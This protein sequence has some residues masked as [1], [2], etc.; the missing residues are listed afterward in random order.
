MAGRGQLE[1]PVLPVLAAVREAMGEEPMVTGKQVRLLRRKQME[2]KSQEAA[3]AAAGMSVRTA[4]RWAS[5]SLPSATK[6]T[7]HW[8]T[9]KDPFVGV[10]EEELVPLL[11]RDEKGILEAK[12]LFVVLEERHPGRFDPGQLRTLQRRLRDWRALRGPAKE[13]FFEQ[14]HPPGREGQF[15][16]T[17]ANGLEVT[18]SGGQLDH[19]L[20]EFILSRSGW[21]WFDIAYGETFEAMLLGLQG[22]LWELDGAPAVVRHDNLSAATHELRRTGGRTLTTRFKDF[23]DHYGL[24]STRIVPGEAHQNGVVEQGHDTTKSAIAQAL[25]LRGSRDFATVAEYRTF[26][27]AVRARLNARIAS[28]L[29]EERPHLR[30]LPPTA[31]PA[32]TTSHP[33]VRRWSTIRVGDRAYSVPSRLIGHQVEARQHADVVEVLY[34]GRVVETMARLRG[35]EEHRIDYRHVIWSLVRKPGA[36]ARY[37]YREDLFPS[38]TF[39]R[40][41]DALRRHRGERGDVE[42][43]RILHL[44][45]STMESEVERALSKLLAEETRLD[46]L[47]VKALAAPSEAA[48]PEMKA[49]EPDLAVYD[50]LLAGGGL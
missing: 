31:M 49:L 15:D 50:A 36:F 46:Y 45:A 14:E 25:E 18:I 6:G 38:L 17:N 40:A 32:Y 42:Y 41:Y 1:W 16:F 20:F 28:R 29:V 22:A 12:T 21:R 34:R 24:R 44:A 8:R 11:E 35:S 43:V 30:P 39:R 2:G 48:I 37:R 7:R 4:R 33:T 10:W 3:A 27:E 19:L 23:L 47:A 26:L 5:G 13:V 9:R